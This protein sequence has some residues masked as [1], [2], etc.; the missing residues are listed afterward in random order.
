MMTRL[1]AI[2]ALLQARVGP[3]LAAKSGGVDF[4]PGPCLLFSIILG[5][6]PLYG[7]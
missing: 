4:H 7:R 6:I 2:S 1:A 5:G 3:R